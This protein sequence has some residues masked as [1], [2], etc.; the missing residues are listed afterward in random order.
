M[1]YPCTYEFWLQNQAQTINE[2]LVF[3]RIYLNLESN[4]KLFRKTKKIPLE[5]FSLGTVDLILLAGRQSF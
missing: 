4:N 2:V 1:V 3:I 5:L